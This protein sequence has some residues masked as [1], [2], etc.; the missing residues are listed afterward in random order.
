MEQKSNL[1]KVYG[2]FF[3]ADEAECNRIN[4]ILAKTDSA[5]FY[6]PRKFRMSIYFINYG[7]ALKVTNYLNEKQNGRYYH[8]FPTSLE[9]LERIKSMY[10]KDKKI[11]KQTPIMY[12]KSNGYKLYDT[13]DD[14]LAKLKETEKSR[15]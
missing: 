14:Y 13:A 12:H 3:M 15:T 1:T 10:G 6:I 2:I 11:R 9:S 8:I 5:L 7:E 4:N